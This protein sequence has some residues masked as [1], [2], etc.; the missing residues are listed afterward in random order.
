MHHCGVSLSEQCIVDLMVC[1]GTHPH[2]YVLQGYVI[3]C[4]TF[5]LMNHIFL[6]KARLRYS[7]VIE[8]CCS[9]VLDG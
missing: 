1:H 2:T 5:I 8:A 4:I 3:I 9:D 6:E 7:P